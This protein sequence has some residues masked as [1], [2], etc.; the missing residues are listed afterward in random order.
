[1][2]AHARETVYDMTVRITR[3]Y[4]GPASRRFITHQVRNHLHK[5]PEDMTKKDLTVLIDWIRI[6]ISLLTNDS[7]VVDEYIEQLKRITRAS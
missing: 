6:S 5:K 2:P 4:L 7:K 1:M 3:D